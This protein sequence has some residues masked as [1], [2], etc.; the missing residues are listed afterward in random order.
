MEKYEQLIAYQ[1]N[2]KYF[3]CIKNLITN[4]KSYVWSFELSWILKINEK[5]LI[6]N[7]IQE[8]FNGHF[9]EYYIYFDTLQDCNAIIDWIESILIINK[10]IK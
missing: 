10:I 2:N 1:E 4:N 5:S 8:K 9:E 7:F 3:L 6:H